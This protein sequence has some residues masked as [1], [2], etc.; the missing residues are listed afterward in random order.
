MEV[1]THFKPKQ[2]KILE[3]TVGNI[4][5]FSEL[6][7]RNFILNLHHLSIF[8]K[9]IMK[10]GN[11]SVRRSLKCLKPQ[12]FMKINTLTIGCL[13]ENLPITGLTNWEG[14]HFARK[15]V[16]NPPID[17]NPPHKAYSIN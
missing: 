1:S 2:H 10:T 15:N 6:K 12:Y 3:I 14:D 16:G 13:V 11:L 17:G 9:I 5:T 8:I 4:I 7:L